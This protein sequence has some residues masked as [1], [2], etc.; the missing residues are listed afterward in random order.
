MKIKIFQLL[1]KYGYT[2]FLAEEHKCENVQCLNANMF[3]EEFLQL[4]VENENEFLT[5]LQVAFTAN[6]PTLGYEKARKLLEEY[7]NQSKPKPRAFN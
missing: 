2:S 1:Q 6:P 3:A 7:A 4:K 5:E